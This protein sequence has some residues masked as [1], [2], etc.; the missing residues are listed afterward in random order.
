MFLSVWG[1]QMADDLTW[2]A[3][4]SKLHMIPQKIKLSF[5]L[6]THIYRCCSGQCHVMIYFLEIF[7]CTF[8]YFSKTFKFCSPSILQSDFIWIFILV[9]MKT[10]KTDLNVCPTT[11]RLTALFTKLPASRFPAVPWFWLV[12]CLWNRKVS[13]GCQW[14]PLAGTT[15]EGHSSCCFFLGNGQ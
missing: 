3:Q 4:N 14:E 7:R 9:E 2:N 10:D 6:F 13:I 11:P 15:S 5:V 8:L 12:Q 1:S